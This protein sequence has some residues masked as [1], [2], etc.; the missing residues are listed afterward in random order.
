MKYN[1]EWN[2]FFNK[3]GLLLYKVK[4]EGSDDLYT[5]GSFYKMDKGNLV[6]CGTRYGRTIGRI[7]SKA[8]VKDLCDF[9]GLRICG[10]AT[11]RDLLINGWV[12]IEDLVWISPEEQEEYYR[13]EE[14][15]DYYDYE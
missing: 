1:K 2:Q 11:K 6:L 8:S 5:F 3:E 14:E 13:E 10:P 7:V 9:S 15:E 12:E 4:H